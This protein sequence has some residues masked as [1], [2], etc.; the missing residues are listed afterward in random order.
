MG[1]AS[2]A[3]TGNGS[4][5]IRQAGA[6]ATCW[7]SGY[8]PRPP[9]ELATAMNFAPECVEDIPAPSHIRRT[10]ESHS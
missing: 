9:E 1:T 7:Q 6:V 5:S 10:D 4:A 8:T 2:A 3:G